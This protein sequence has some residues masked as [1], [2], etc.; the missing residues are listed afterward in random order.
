[1]KK[2]SS[3]KNL[4]E[5]TRLMIET[6]PWPEGYVLLHKYGLLGNGPMSYE[7]M[8]Y[9][10]NK[11]PS[12]IEDAEMSGLRRLRNPAYQQLAEDFLKSPTN[13]AELKSISP[14]LTEVIE[15]ISKL[16]PGLVDHLRKCEDDLIKLQPA[17]FEHLVA[18]F[19][20]SWGFE[21][22]RL[23]GRNSKTSA[24]IF[25]AR[26]IHPLEI[27]VRFFVEVKRWKHKIGVEVIDR[28]YGAMI[29]ERPHI[30]WN[31]AL[32]V[33]LVGF[34]DFRKYDRQDWHLKELN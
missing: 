4:I 5:I 9:K 25:A 24:D 8:G 32:I 14:Q 17:V 12:E 28:V 18:E 10:I 3:N 29:S 19:F 6:L 30:G 27:N 34:K 1:M 13:A 11:S 26:R 20:A 22:V 2:K 31:A 16:T 21:D 15:K 33:S 23:V 7:D